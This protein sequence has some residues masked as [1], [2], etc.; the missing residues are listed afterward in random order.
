MDFLNLALNW[1]K[2]GLEL[3]TSFVFPISLTETKLKTISV[4]KLKSNFPNE[5]FSNDKKTV[6]IFPY[7]NTFIRESIWLLKYRKNE[8]AINIFAKALGESIISLCEDQLPFYSSPQ[9]IL[10]PI[11]NHI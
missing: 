11:P 1:V 5:W 7:K 8:Y 9:I 2:N 6:A 3:L 4:E 10:I